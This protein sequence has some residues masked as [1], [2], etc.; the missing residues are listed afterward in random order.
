MAKKWTVSALTGG[1]FGCLDAIDGN[2]LSDGDA[3]FVTIP[4]STKEISFYTLDADSGAEESSPNVISPDDNAGTKRWILAPVKG[5]SI[6][7]LGSQES[8]DE[9]LEDVVPDGILDLITVTEEGGLNVQWSSGEVHISGVII[10]TDAR[11]TDY[12]LT[13]DSINYIYATVAG[14]STLVVDTTL[15]ETERVLVATIWTHDG[16]I[17]KVVQELVISHKFESIFNH[18]SDTHNQLVHSGLNVEID[19]DGTNAN[20][21]TVDTGSYYVNPHEKLSLAAKF[22]SSGSDHIQDLLHRYFHVSGAWSTEYSNGVAFGFWD[23]GTDKEATAANKWYCGFIF[24]ER[25]DHFDYMFPQVEY[26]NEDDARNASIVYPPDHEEFSML[27]ARFV[28]KG[29]ESD[30]DG[31]AYLLDARPIHGSTVTS[32]AIQALW[33]TITADTGSATATDSDDTLAI[34]GGSGI[35]TAVVGKELTIKR[36]DSYDFAFI[37]AA[38][39]VPATTNPAEAGT[40]EY[41]T[42]DQDFDYFAFDGGAIKERVEFAMA[43]PDNW[44]LGTIKVKVY[45]SSA[46][47]S[48]AGDTYEF[49]IKGVAISNSD[50]L[51]VAQGTPQVISDTLLAD[52]GT[53][54]QISDATPAITIGGSPALGDLINF[55]IYRNTDGTDDMAED[56][57]L[58]GVSI[59]FL[60]TGQVSAW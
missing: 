7:V 8:L 44:N 32:G 47:G 45:A 2:K 20:D 36:S 29:T 54:L 10:E 37:P 18:L 13:D 22:Y 3:A 53:D 19:S 59:Q 28:F 57:W 21:F 38:A 48:S 30:F 41:G 17:H 34:A 6:T 58:L 4:G 52:N 39:M 24:L 49:G 51:D 23:N 40:N 43:L 1:N 60:K 5:S 26:S 31:K 9:I 11:E 42:N 14:D 25:E 33:K 50:P 12:A 56:A 55:E 15:P 16:S 46:S 27:L 35:S